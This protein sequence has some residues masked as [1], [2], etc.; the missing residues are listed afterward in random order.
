MR[1]QAELREATY[2]ISN[3]RYNTMHCTAR[4]YIP[5]LSYHPPHLLHLASPHLIPSYPSPPHPFPSHPNPSDPVLAPPTH[6]TRTRNQYASRQSIMRRRAETIQRRGTVH[7]L[8]ANICINFRVNTQGAADDLLFISL[9]VYSASSTSFFS[10][11][12]NAFL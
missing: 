6:P 7:H 3:M 1:G 5:L 12:A 9:L 2:F 4:P 8:V 10:I 11:L